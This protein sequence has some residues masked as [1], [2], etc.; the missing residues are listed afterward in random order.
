VKLHDSCVQNPCTPKLAR[1]SIYFVRSE[2]SGNIKIGWTKNLWVRLNHMQTQ[3]GDTITLRIHIA[4]EPG[5]SLRAAEASLHKMFEEARIYSEWYEPHPTL[6]GLI[7]HLRGNMG[8]D[9]R[10]HY[11]SMQAMFIADP[12]DLSGSYDKPRRRRRRA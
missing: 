12:V 9:E 11:D 10:D 2:T 4:G 1:E 6:I 8:Q 7:D 3:S 5:Q